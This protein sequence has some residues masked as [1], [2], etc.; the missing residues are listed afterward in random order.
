MPTTFIV[1]NDGNVA[2]P[3]GYTINAKVWAANV[4][5]VSSDLTGFAHS[6]R[7]RRLG[8]SDIT[9]SISGTPVHGTG[10]PWGSAPVTALPSQPGGTI[11]LSVNGGTVT[12]TNGTTAYLQFGAVFNSWAFNSDKNGESTLS[13]N[14]EMNASNGPT[15]VWQTT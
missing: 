7:V 10:T 11:T 3:A 4:A 8:V 13:M 6:G 9:G 12:A 14:F 2:L 5:Y 15:I 1:G